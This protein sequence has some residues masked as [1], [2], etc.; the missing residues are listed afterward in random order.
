MPCRYPSYGLLGMFSV[1]GPS[2]GIFRV[3][4]AAFPYLLTSRIIEKRSRLNRAVNNRE[5]TVGLKTTH[6]GC[7]G[8]IPSSVVHC[9]RDGVKIGFGV[10]SIH[11]HVF[12]RDCR[13]VRLRRHIL[14]RISC[15]GED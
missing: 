6:R 12:A 9:A 2:S 10:N 1:R 7:A 4:I 15:R 3:S 11:W 14:V 13:L 5:R 8:E